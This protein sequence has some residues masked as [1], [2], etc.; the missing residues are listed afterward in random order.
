MWE[1]F[2]GLTGRGISAE[3][4]RLLSRAFTEGEELTVIVK[5]AGGEIE[6]KGRISSAEVLPTMRERVDVKLQFEASEK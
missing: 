5:L 4:I 3:K 2:G 1:L 6:L